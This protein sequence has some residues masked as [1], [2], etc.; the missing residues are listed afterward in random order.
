MRLLPPLHGSAGLALGVAL[1]VLF[2]TGLVTWL[3]RCRL[4]LPARNRATDFPRSP[5]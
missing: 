2:A 1:A 4:P 5:A 3:V